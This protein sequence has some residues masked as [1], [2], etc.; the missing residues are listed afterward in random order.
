VCNDNTFNITATG[1]CVCP[2]NTSLLTNTCINC[3]I[4]Y[5]TQCSSANVCQACINNLVANT[6][7]TQC[8]CSSGQTL[9]NSNCYTCSVP[10]CVTC[11]ATN[12]CNQCSTNF[13]PNS[14][15]ACVCQTGYTL[16]GS[17]CV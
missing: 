9:F 2:A 17:T 16:S 15:G 1:Q 7:G 12:V 3:S 14:L 10:N 11:N 6:A 4:Q 8:Q 13:V 5:C